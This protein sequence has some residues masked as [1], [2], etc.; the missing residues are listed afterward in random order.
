MGL[1]ATSF[2]S[3]PFPRTGSQQPKDPAMLEAARHPDPH[4][5]Q[6]E[7]AP[8]EEVDFEARLG[9]S[10]NGSTAV[11]ERKPG[12][13]G[14][15]QMESE[16]VLVDREALLAELRRV[17]DVQT[18]EALLGVLDK[19]A[20]QVRA[21]GISREDFSELKQIVTQLA[22][23]QRKA[24]VRLAGVED[25]LSR[26]EETVAQLVEAQRKAEIRLEG[27][28][29]RLSRLEGIVAQLAEALRDLADKVAKL[30]E[31]MDRLT[32]KVARLDGRVLE[33]TYREKAGA[34]FGPL[35]R[36]LRVVSPHSLEDSLEAILSHEE[37]RDVLL[38][39]LLISGQPRHRPQMSEVWLAVEVS[40]VVDAEDV[41]RAQRR[42][43]L[44][45]RAGYRAIPAV[46]GESI[47]QG[48]EAEAGL[49][50]VAVLQDGRSLL[51]EEALAT[52][53]EAGG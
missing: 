51:W 33:T 35:L 2:F 20:G 36:R 5:A 48:A 15:S 14:A 34:Y 31:S 44:L 27:V 8:Q 43:A 41:A 18:A 37:F 47:T 25:R 28:E 42:A 17:F 10:R 19:V 52:W 4:P 12:K 49:H 16:L 6:T 1:P 30:T 45:R 11:I 9:Y 40:V 50:K 46:A 13:M 32:D 38:L 53:E 22:E 39:D 29:D 24:E 7:W 21:A 23:A 3:P 26:L